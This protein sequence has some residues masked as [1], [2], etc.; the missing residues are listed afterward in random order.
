MKLIYTLLYK[1]MA[2]IEHSL[3]SDLIH[4]TDAAGRLVAVEEPISYPGP[5]KS[6]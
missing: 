5:S 1:P 4:L 2:V 3:L 6:R